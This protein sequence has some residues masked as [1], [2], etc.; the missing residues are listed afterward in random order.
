MTSAVKEVPEGVKMDF[1]SFLALLCDLS[2]KAG[3]IARLIRRDEKLLELL[4]E[5]KTDDAANPRFVH[6]FKTL[7]DVL[8]QE[9]IR[10]YVGAKYPEVS[11]RG[12]EDSTFTNGAGEH[13]TVAVADKFEETLACL[14]Q[15]LEGKAH[16]AKL[17][18]EELHREV[19]A[20]VEIEEISLDLALDKIGIWIDPIDG[21]AEYIKGVHKPSR[22]ANIPASGLQCVT[23]LIGVYDLES[24]IPLAGVINQPFSAAAEDDTYRSAIF[25][26]V[27]CGDTRSTN[28][29][30][31]AESNETKIAVLSSSE[32]TKFTKFLKQKLRADIVYSAGAGHKLLKLITGDADLNLLS[33]GTTFKWDTCAGQAIL[34]AMSGNV[35]SLNDTIF[36]GKPVPLTYGSKEPNCNLNGILAYREEN[37]IR[38]IIA[39]FAGK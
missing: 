11:I 33:R 17:L 1:R 3:N 30:A 8:I 29:P 6:D 19:T 13:V 25:W 24:G 28:V 35:L 5:E 27:C 38:E 14:E 34:M 10:K 37:T 23:I 15:V 31:R 12:E 32:Q 36:A 18:A 9:M 4:V 22:F 39:M 7:A 16:E 26:G 21:T 20:D 2:E